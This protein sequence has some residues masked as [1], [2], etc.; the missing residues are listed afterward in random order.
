M[1]AA[2]ASAPASPPSQANDA[3]SVWER[4]RALVADNFSVA[5]IVEP[6]T[7][8]RLDGNLAIII[9]PTMTALGAARTRRGA[10]EDGLTKA[11]GRPVRIELRASEK[12]VES[13]EAIQPSHPDP[14]ARAKAMSNPLV[15]RAVE[16]FDG[17]VVDVSEDQG[18]PHV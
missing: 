18:E 15:R 10:I 8:D 4:F 14:A 11:I 5:P 13:P 12:P 3:A 16:L 9:A 7:L 2:P 6:L 1:H 17:R